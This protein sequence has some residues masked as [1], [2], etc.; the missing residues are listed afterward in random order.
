MTLPPS[1]MM[2]WQRAKQVLTPASSWACRL[3]QPAPTASAMRCVI[4]SSPIDAR[5]EQDFRRVVQPGSVT[6]PGN[7]KEA[8]LS[9]PTG[10]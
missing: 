7:N 3:F 1:Q 5:L 2:E 6:M 10:P 8:R 9:V 4:F